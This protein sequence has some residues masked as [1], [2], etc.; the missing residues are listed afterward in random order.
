ME[1]QP[2]TYI[3][4]ILEDRIPLEDQASEVG[5]GRAVGSSAEVL[6][7]PFANKKPIQPTNQRAADKKMFGVYVVRPD[8]RVVHSYFKHYV[9]DSANT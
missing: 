2:R 7:L 9:M 4:G 1:S 8:T 5:D 6:L 3:R